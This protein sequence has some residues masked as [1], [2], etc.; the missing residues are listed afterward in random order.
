MRPKKL[1]KKIEKNENFSRLFRNP[2]KKR[3][4]QIHP[5]QNK[6]G[7]FLEQFCK[8]LNSKS[9]FGRNW[10]ICEKVLFCFIFFCRDSSVTKFEPKNL[11]RHFCKSKVIS[12]VENFGASK[13]AQKAKLL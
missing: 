12:N 7:E 9:N 6:N 3:P 2:T 1:W 8:V 11:P 10:S 13:S 4:R 5:V